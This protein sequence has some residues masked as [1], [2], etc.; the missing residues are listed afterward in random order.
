MSSSGAGK[1]AIAATSRP[2]EDEGVLEEDVREEIGA[3]RDDAGE[4]VEAAEDEPS[5]GLR[6]TVHR[7]CLKGSRTL[8]PETNEKG[9]RP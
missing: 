7:G 2:A 4:R 1:A 3:D 6:G 8:A 5:P 9:S